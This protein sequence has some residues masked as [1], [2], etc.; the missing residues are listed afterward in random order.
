MFCKIMSTTVVDFVGLRGGVDAKVPGLQAQPVK[1]M[2]HIDQLLPA[3]LIVEPAAGE[4]QAR[5]DAIEDVQ[6][7]AVSQ[8]RQR[9]PRKTDV[10]SG[11]LFLGLL[12]LAAHLRRE[13]LR[14][15]LRKG[16][17]ASQK[18]R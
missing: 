6:G 5:D 4:I 12:D 13:R 9:C 14:R 10:D 8:I 18:S 16:H 7:I 15:H 3:E 17:R 1:G 2:H 11:D